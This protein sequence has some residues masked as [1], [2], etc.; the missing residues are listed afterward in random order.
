MA[1]KIWPGDHGEVRSISAKMKA[2]L[3]KFRHELDPDENYKSAFHIPLLRPIADLDGANLKIILQMGVIPKYRKSLADKRIDAIL[4][5]SGEPNILT[6][7][8]WEETR[9][10]EAVYAVVRGFLSTTLPINWSALEDADEME[11]ARCNPD[12]YAPL[13]QEVKR[14]SILP[15]PRT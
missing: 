15:N 8:A 7:L 5:R 12:T 1:Q 9:M 13:L 6:I 14:A 10:S 4:W 11:R 2:N 3:D